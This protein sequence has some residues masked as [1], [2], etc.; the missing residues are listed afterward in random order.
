[1]TR[2]SDVEERPAFC[3]RPNREQTTQRAVSRAQ[4]GDQEALTKL[5]AE[6]MDTIASLAWEYSSPSVARD[7]LI[8][9]GI[10]GL[11]AS[12]MQCESPKGLVASY[13]SA[14]VRQHVREAWMSNNFL[15]SKP[16]GHKGPDIYVPID[17]DRTPL[18][19][20]EANQH[21][22]PPDMRSERNALV[23]ELKRAMRITLNGRERVVIELY[24]GLNGQPRLNLRVIAC[25]L[26]VC[27]ERIRQIRN[28][29]LDKLRK[30]T[31]LAEYWG[32]N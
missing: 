29:A 8:C 1:M 30:G 27:P 21:Y 15:V 3:T 10:Q 16:R 31:S 26:S 22:E 13:V 4:K 11:I 2:A 7:D 24:Y 28:V 32:R 20:T 17:D 6:N 14:V 23:A 9:A 18:A 5:I 25:C 19:T 12:V